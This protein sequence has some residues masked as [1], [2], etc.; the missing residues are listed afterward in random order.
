MRDVVRSVVELVRAVSP[1]LPEHHRVRQGGRAGRDMHGGASGEVQPSHLVGPSARI[2]RP[3][4]D[5]VVYDGRPDEH[6]DDAGEHAASLGDGT[7]GE[8]DG[9][10]R[11]HAL[12]DGEEEVGDLVG[13]HGRAGEDVHE[14]E[15]REI[16]DER[17]GG[18]GEGQRVAPEEPL[19]ACDGGGHDGEP[20]QRQGRLAPSKTR[21]EEARVGITVSR[22]GSAV[23][24]QRALLH[25][26]L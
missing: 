25:S 10:G 24:S 14:A 2:P 13:A 21:V 19:E 9:D 22:P 1:P 16:T 8:R 15:I 6:E 11:E 4:R 7:G 12:V 3:A 5:G 23:S 18:M 20:Y 26:T 17:A